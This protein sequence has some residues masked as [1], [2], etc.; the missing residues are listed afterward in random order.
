MTEY[1]ESSASGAVKGRHALASSTR[2][3]SGAARVLVVAPDHIAELGRLTLSHGAYTV[4]QTANVA[5]A[6]ALKHEWRPHRL[7][8]DLDLTSREAEKL[9]GEII[10]GIRVPAIALTA[11]GDLRTKLLAFEQGADDFLTLPFAPDELIARA[12]AIMRR[13]YGEGA[14]LVPVIRV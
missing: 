2:S 7:V 8:V 13:T 5:D 12:H 1:A 6:E 9:L 11:R 4:R 14:P 10:G 3:I